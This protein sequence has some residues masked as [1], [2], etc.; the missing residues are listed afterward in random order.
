MI[1][2]L[3]DGREFKLPDGTDESAADRIVR[4][5][6]T[7]ETVAARA[8]DA[9]AAAQ[10][11]VKAL[12]DKLDAILAQPSDSGKVI[13]ELRGLRNDLKNGIVR[14]VSAQLA[15]VEIVKDA[16]GEPVRS[17]KVA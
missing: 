17:R 4:V 2:E 6:V 1:I 11:E 9:A 8:Q 13:E 14:I 16:F 7:A 10:A 5:L 12:R 15:D 3:S